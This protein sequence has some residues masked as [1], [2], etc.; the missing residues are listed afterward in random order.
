VNGSLPEKSEPLS[1][2]RY[3]LLAREAKTPDAQLSKDSALFGMK[4]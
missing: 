3:S 2:A 1:D 4:I